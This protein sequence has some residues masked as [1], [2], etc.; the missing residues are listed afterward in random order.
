MLNLASQE[1]VCPSSRQRLKSC[2]SCGVA[3]EVRQSPARLPPLPAARRRS[4]W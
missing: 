1:Q 4:T 2:V 3:P